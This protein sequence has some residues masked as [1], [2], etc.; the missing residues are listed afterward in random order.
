MVTLKGCMRPRA[1]KDVSS[2]IVFMSLKRTDQLHS[3]L[4]ISK[5]EV[6]DPLH[7]KVL[8]ICRWGWHEPRGDQDLEPDAFPDTALVTG[9]I[10]W[11]NTPKWLSTSIRPIVNVGQWWYFML[12]TQSGQPNSLLRTRLE[13]H[14]SL[15]YSWLILVLCVG[16]LNFNI[17]SIT[18]YK[19]SRH[20]NLGIKSEI[21]NVVLNMTTYLL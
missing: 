9:L 2:T 8:F 17:L 13:V 14:L 4:T 19:G 6:I 15:L 3:T 5:Q 1:W 12:Y 10:Y 18:E 11:V 21:H 7:L 16:K 20:P